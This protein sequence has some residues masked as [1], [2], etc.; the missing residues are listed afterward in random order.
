MER[1]LL[2]LGKAAEH[3][4]MHCPLS[5]RVMKKLEMAWYETGQG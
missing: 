3:G 5:R 2:Y 1:R 4:L